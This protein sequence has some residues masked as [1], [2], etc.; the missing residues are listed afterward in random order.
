[1]HFCPEELRLILIF[2]NYCASMYHYYVCGFKTRFLGVKEH[3]VSEHE[4]FLS[5]E[6]AEDDDGNL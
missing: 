1:M 6:H 3:D 2:A 5:S 4:Y